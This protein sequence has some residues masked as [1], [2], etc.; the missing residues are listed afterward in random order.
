[1]YITAS[2]SNGRSI[3]NM[4][5]M[6]KNRLVGMGLK[7]DVKKNIASTTLSSKLLFVHSKQIYRNLLINKE[8]MEGFVS[9]MSPLTMGTEQRP[10][11]ELIRIEAQSYDVISGIADK[12]IPAVFNHQCHLV[13]EQRYYQG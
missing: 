2:H 4:I 6:V 11:R 7:G 1:M 3:E 10:I 9:C 8:N 12:N 5:G 13:R